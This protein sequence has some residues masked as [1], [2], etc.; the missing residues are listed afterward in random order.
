MPAT[1]TIPSFTHSVPHKTIRAEIFG[2]VY[3]KFYSH[4]GQ[5]EYLRPLPLDLQPKDPRPPPLNISDFE[6]FRTLGYGSTASVVYARTVRNSHPLDRPGSVLAVKIV[7]KKHLR[8]AD[9]F[10]ENTPESKQVERSIL[11]E[12][13]WNPFVCGLIGTFVDACNVYYAFEFCPQNS[14]RVVLDIGD[15]L[16]PAVARFYFCGIVAGLAF[17]HDHDIVHRD[18][19]P[20]NI[21]LGPG[22]YPVIGDLGSARRMQDDFVQIKEREGAFEINH[23]TLPFDW[24]EVGT[25]VYN[26]PEQYTAMTESR[27]VGPNIDWW[28]AGITLFEMLT[29][30]YPFYS[31]DQNKMEEMIKRGKYRWPSGVRVGAMVKALVAALL[32]LDPL[33]RL[34]THDAQEV[35]ENPWFEN[36]DW[37]KY[38]SRQ[39]VPPTRRNV[40]PGPGERWHEFALPMQK[41]VPGLKVTEPPLELAYDTRFKLK[42]I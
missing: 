9:A 28:A 16:E 42:E 14:L 17:L 35:M 4:L 7:E 1:R 27:Y 18:V 6:A 26:A 12:L 3:R 31:R 36:V 5:P 20:E 10:E 40:Y 32:T 15:Q 41:D 25:F 2:K 21:F 19:K 33:E 29:R 11:T 23:P 37:A 13:P 24:H 22:G 38:H 30:Q 34:G 8:E 39:Y